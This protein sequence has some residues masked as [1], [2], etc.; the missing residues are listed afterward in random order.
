M[1]KE[2]KGQAGGFDLACECGQAGG[3]PF[4]GECDEYVHCT[5][6]RTYINEEES[7]L[8]MKPAGR[9]V[10]L[11]FGN[12]WELGSE[13]RDEIADLLARELVCASK[14][15]LDKSSP[16]ILVVGLGNDEMVFDSVGS[17]VCGRLEADGESLFVFKSVVFGKSGIKSRDLVK[18]L[19]ACVGADI[20]VAVDSLVARSDAR[21]GRVIQLADSGI[22]PGSGVGKHLGKIDRQSVGVPVLALGVP[23]ALFSG[24]ELSELGYLAIPQ[25]VL[26]IVEKSSE[27]LANALKTFALEM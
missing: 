13:A 6:S 22:A 26:L 14:T 8:I 12:V 27:I 24:E 17:R 23:S 15:V 2:T 16:K 9:Y 10:S 5:V 21:V 18:N 20:V 1:D 4:M 25:T 3:L 19:V 7:K 11:F